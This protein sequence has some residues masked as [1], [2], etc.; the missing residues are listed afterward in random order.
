WIKLNSINKVVCK[1]CTGAVEK[2]MPLP[3]TTNCQSSKEA[4]VEKGFDSCKNPSRL[5]SHESGEFHRQASLL[6]ELTKKKNVVEH[7]S[8]A[9]LIEMR[10]NRIALE[11]IFSTILVLARQGL[12]LRGNEND[13]NS[14]FKQ[15]LNMRAEDV[16][17]LKRWL[18]RSSYTFTSHQIVDEILTMMADTVVRQ[19]LQEI[20]AARH[21]SI[22]IDETAD[23]SRSEQ[24]SVCFR[25]ASDD[26]KSS[27][28]FLGFYKAENTMAE[29]LFKI[30]QD[31]FARYDLDFEKLRGQCYDG[32]TNM[33][34]QL[35]GLQTRIR[36][37]EPRA[38][39]VHCNAHNLSLVVQDGIENVLP[40]KNFVGIVREL[41]NFIRDSPRRLST[42]KNL[43]SD[44]SPDLSPFCPTRYVLK[45]I[46]KI[47]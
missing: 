21:F 25:I 29:T 44:N 18:N 38:L 40:I 46:I 5:K 6:L 35:T 13:E 47:S 22:L 8:S 9:K 36:E 19:L 27:E 10:D 41:I 3:N 11:K 45:I 24:V 28:I 42:F 12:A 1:V 43:Q 31:V 7:L 37:L 17:E 16:P 30:V 20:K 34:G 33:S 2:R 4:F 39:F 14:H 26:L 15:L 32:A 23:I